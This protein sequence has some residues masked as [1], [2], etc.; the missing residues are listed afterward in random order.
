MPG[1]IVASRRAV[2]VAV[3]VVTAA[4]CSAAHQGAAHA[5]NPAVTAHPHA[6]HARPRTP[7]LPGIYLGIGDGPWYGPKVRPR[8][9]LLGADWTVTRIRWADWTQ[10]HAD[11]RGYYVACAGAGGPCDDFWAVIQ[12]THVREHHGAR[13]F[14]IMKIT[15]R[16]HRV[17]WLVMST[18]Q[19]SWFQR[20]RPR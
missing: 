15:G 1:V 9:L 16:H 18:Q 5:R 13:Y 3:L 11:G 19:G 7:E 10:Q 12:V 6:A 14:A 20:A 17:E 2:A 8:A 4:G